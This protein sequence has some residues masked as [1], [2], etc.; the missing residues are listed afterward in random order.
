MI[1]PDPTRVL[2]DRA[3]VE[4]GEQ[5]AN[6]WVQQSCIHRYKNGSIRSCP[7]GSHP[8]NVQRVVVDWGP[9][10][11]VYHGAWYPIE[12]LGVPPRPAEPGVD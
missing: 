11:G 8:F 12:P 1:G 6:I 7:L 10:G 9:D 5:P 4:W 3:R 2:L